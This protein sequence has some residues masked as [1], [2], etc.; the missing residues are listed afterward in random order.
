M[1]ALLEKPPQLDEMDHVRRWLEIAAP[2]RDT[3]ERH[4]THLHDP[5]E[6]GN[7][8]AEENVLFALENLHTYPC[9]QQGLTAGTLH[10]H[11]WFFDIASA[12]LFAYNNGPR[13]FLPLVR[14]G[15]NT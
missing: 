1:H 11:G 13:Q 6:R 5:R 15:K 7:A 9:I 2:V 12:R 8:A 10:L 4:Y 3:V 14:G